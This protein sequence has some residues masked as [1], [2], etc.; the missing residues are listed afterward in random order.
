MT[1]QIKELNT[2][3]TTERSEWESYLGRSLGATIYHTLGWMDAVEKT[4]SHRPRYLMARRGEEVV[5]IFPMFEVHSWIA[6]TILVSVPYAV[7]GGALSDDE[8]VLAHLLQEIKRLSRQIGARYVDIRSSKPMW[9][10]L[11]TVDRYATFIKYLPVRAGD[12]VDTFPRK[13]RAEIRRARDKF[14]ITVHFDDGLLKTVWELYARSMRR[15][16]S[17]NVPYRFFQSLIEQTPGQH[18]VSVLDYQDRP[19]AGLVSFIHRDAILPYFSG[20]D[21]HW[22][23]MTGANNY[24]YASLMEKSVSMGLRRFDFGRTRIDNTGSFQFKK[25]Q[26][27]EPT[28]LGYQCYVPSGGAMPNLTPSNRKFHVAQ[29]VWKRLPLVLTRPLGGWLSASIPG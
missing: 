2:S 25:N 1:L 3:L 7:Y 6:G 10:D 26:G 23:S 8:D 4:F 18:L 27:F 15:L 24:L 22:A 12:V 29:W 5:G 28:P 11:P 17:P 20:C 9:S 14:G 21:E 16:G 19:I 13:A